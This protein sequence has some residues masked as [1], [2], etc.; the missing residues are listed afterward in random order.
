MSLF[1]KK[2]KKRRNPE[3]AA[4]KK[5]KALRH[6]TY[7]VV[8]I[9]LMISVLFFGYRFASSS[10]FAIAK[11]EVTNNSVIPPDKILGVSGV[12]VGS[13]ILTVSSTRINKNFAGEPWVNRI[14]VIRKLP[15]VVEL[16]V[17]ERKPIAIIAAK[18][19]RFLVDR[20][21][22]VLGADNGAPLPVIVAGQINE[23]KVN[24]RVDDKHFQVGLSYTSS[25]PQQ[26]YQAIKEVR[27]DGDNN[28]NATTT[29][30]TEIKYGFL[31]D[32]DKKNYVLNVILSKAKV[33]G[34]AL[35]L[36]DVRVV[37]NPVI[38]KVGS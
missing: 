32:V 19:G 2:K 26:V 23:I 1:K 12:K 30:G 33:E 31:E 5:K 38:K 34:Q 11:V 17:T 6:R 21:S 29:G 25:L 24:Q 8:G 10:Y 9:V 16:R 27:V 18:N 3:I 4:K 22:I 13:N 7:G 37:S 15:N 28:L 20:Y 35:Q 14:D 36:V